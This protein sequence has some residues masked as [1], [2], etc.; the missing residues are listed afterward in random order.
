VSPAPV[1]PIE[2]VIFDLDG[3]LCDYDFEARLAHMARA[4]GRPAPE[5]RA[6][7]FDSGWDE[8]SDRG[9]IGTEDYLEGCA[10]RLKAPV[11]RAAWL[12]ARA[13]AM[14]PKD[15]VLDLAETLA[16]RVAVAVF[17]NNN[18]LLA[19]ALPAILPRIPAIF[20]RQVFFSA[21]LGLSKP[22]PVS[23]RAVL[24]RLGGIAP[25]RALFVDDRADYLAGARRAGLE[26]H[27]F[28][29]AEGLRADLADYGLP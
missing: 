20:G 21:A 11:P 23:F 14:S 2:A 13:S 26:V 25:A 7:I 18:L 19:E 6:E 12:A 29:G 22:D 10:A 9:E 5:I 27:L 8:M 28:K 16:A 4:I 1:P 15:D 3:V 24:A 17:T